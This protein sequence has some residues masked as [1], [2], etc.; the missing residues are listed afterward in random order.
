MSLA[1]SRRAVVTGAGAAAAGVGATGWRTAAHG[2]DYTPGSWPATRVLSARNRHLVSR[3]SYGVTQELA[4]QV[5]DAGGSRAWFGEQ[6][7]SAYDGST[8]GLADWWPDLHLD[9]ATLWNRQVD[10][11]RGGYRVM[12]DYGRRLLVRRLSP[13][14]RCWR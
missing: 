5:R 14:A 1:P 3:F 10:Q 6:L 8:D 11:T 13:P 2:A 12:Y 4:A 7:A 9:P